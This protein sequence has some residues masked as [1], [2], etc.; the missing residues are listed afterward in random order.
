MLPLPLVVVV[1]TPSIWLKALPN[2]IKCIYAHLTV[3]IS[4]GVCA[5]VRVCCDC[6]VAIHQHFSSFNIFFGQNILLVFYMNFYTYSISIYY[7][8][9]LC[10]CVCV[11]V[12][13][14]GVSLLPCCRCRCLP[15]SMCLL[16]YKWIWFS[17]LKAQR[18]R[19]YYTHFI[20]LKFSCVIVIHYTP[21]PHTFIFYTRPAA[22]MAC[23]LYIR[24]TLFAGK[25]DHCRIFKK[26]C[27]CFKEFHWHL[28][29]PSSP[30]ILY[31]CAIIWHGV[32]CLSLWD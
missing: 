25:C 31:A 1:A 14:D 7:V 13:V 12:R 24:G 20:A 22:S 23:M 5:C 19:T 16:T 10:V 15:Q 17:G 9:L 18:E 26:N 6:V 8:P 29:L 28:S 11:M 2:I 27:V 3:Y 30:I 4:L 21:Q 32:V